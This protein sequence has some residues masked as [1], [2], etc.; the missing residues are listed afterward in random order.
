[1]LFLNGSVSLC[2][3][4]KRIKTKK[5]TREVFLFYTTQNVESIKKQK[6][7][8]NH[9]ESESHIVFNRVLCRRRRRRH[10]P[11]YAPAHEK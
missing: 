4:K 5:P 1:M 7:V 3:S 2:F 6:P 9:S 8:K 10:S 11:S